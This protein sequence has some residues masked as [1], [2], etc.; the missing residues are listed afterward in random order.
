M[1]FTLLFLDWVSQFGGDVFKKWKLHYFIPNHSFVNS[2][3]L[4]G[5]IGKGK[6]SKNR[7][8]CTF[9]LTWFRANLVFIIMSL[10]EA[11]NSSHFDVEVMKEW[12]C[13]SE[14]CLSNYFLLLLMLK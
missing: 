8:S 3:I 4:H 7:S 12:L 2:K 1:Y 13:G 14:K 6:V 5:S 11:S 10:K 9:C